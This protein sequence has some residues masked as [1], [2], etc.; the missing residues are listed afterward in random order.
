MFFS[1]IHFLYTKATDYIHRR[2]NLEI[3]G[4]D[5][6]ISVKA[7]GARIGETNNI[8]IKLIFLLFQSFTAVGPEDCN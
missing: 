6:A 4:T 7:L 3:H 8:V 1:S 5:T 2:I